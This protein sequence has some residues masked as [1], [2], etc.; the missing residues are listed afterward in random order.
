MNSI[1]PD[2]A[3]IKDLTAAQNNPTMKIRTDQP[4][5]CI[6]R[7]RKPLSDA[8]DG[9]HIT[10]PPGHFRME[11]GAAK[12]FQMRLIVPGTRNLEV[13]GFQSWI[14]ILGT[15]DGR[16]KV[17]KPELC[18][19]FTDEELQ[20]FGEAVEAID[21]SA[22]SNAADRDVKPTSVAQVQAH[23]FGQGGGRPQIDASAQA[24]P[25]AAEAADDVFAPPAESAT[26]EAQAEAQAEG[27]APAATGRRRR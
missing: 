20:K 18:R 15:E 17:D 19:P 26:R 11:Y 14:G 4:V 9:R 6:N 16:I 7:G 2:G 5:V 3:E 24:T 25:G 10:I 23:T 22:M 21:R 8:F 12:H 13:G 27:A 1:I